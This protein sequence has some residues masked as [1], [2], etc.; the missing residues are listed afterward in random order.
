MYRQFSG[1]VSSTGIY[2]YMYGTVVYYLSIINY[3]INDL[4]KCQ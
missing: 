2:A 4:D 1:C 3:K